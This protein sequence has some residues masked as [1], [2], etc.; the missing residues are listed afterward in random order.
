MQVSGRVGGVSR[1]ANVSFP[2]KPWIPVRSSAKSPMARV[3][4]SASPALAAR[5]TRATVPVQVSG[6]VGGVSRAASAGLERELR[7]WV[8]SAVMRDVS[9]AAVRLSRKCRFGNSTHRLDAGVWA[10]GRSFRSG[11]SGVRAGAADYGPFRGERAV[12]RRSLS[13]SPAFAACE[14]RATVS[15]QVSRAAGEVSHAAN[16]GLAQ[17]VRFR[18]LVLVGVRWRHNLCCCDRGGA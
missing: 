1:V 11:K 4:L 8:L 3:S 10:G 7:I 12:S 14:T 2:N 5:E 16:A 13:G 6:W 9:L 18:L 15:S 17:D